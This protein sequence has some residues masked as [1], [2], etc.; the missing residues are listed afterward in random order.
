MKRTRAMMNKTKEKNSPSPDSSSR[1]SYGWDP[2]TQLAWRQPR[3][4]AKAAREFSLPPEIPQDALEDAALEVE[5]LDGSKKVVSEVTVAVV[6]SAMIRR[7][8]GGPPLLEYEHHE[9]HNKITLVQRL[10]RRLLFSVFEQSRQICQ[11]RVDTFGEVPEALEALPLTDLAITR[12]I[13]FWTPILVAYTKGEIA[14]KKGIMDA[15]NKALKL[16]RL[17]KPRAKKPPGEKTTQAKVEGKAKVTSSPLSD[18]SLEDEG[19]SSAKESPR[20]TKG[21]QV[22]KDVGKSVAASSTGMTPL[23]A[24]LIRERV[25][26]ANKEMAAPFFMADRR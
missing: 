9:T 20:N 16:G 3:G 17:V 21:K 15:R 24:A 19:A 18:F 13:E 4:A 26:K 2:E 5:F 22:A 25:S 10:D 7:S 11:L 12:G 23:V 14:D 6:K 8:G 1:F